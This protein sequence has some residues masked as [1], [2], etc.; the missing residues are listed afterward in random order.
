MC[1][2]AERRHLA[3]TGV[4]F[5]AGGALPFTGL[6]DWELEPS[7]C[8]SLGVPVGLLRGQHCLEGSK[9]GTVPNPMEISD[10]SGILLVNFL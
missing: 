7:A 6:V 5:L 4:C 9:P 10:L 1:T 2:E 8:C 3:G